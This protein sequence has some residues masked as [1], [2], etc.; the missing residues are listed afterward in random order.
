MIQF[1]MNTLLK[2]KNPAFEIADAIYWVAEKNGE[3]VGRIAAIALDMELKEKKLIRFGWIDF[4]DDL[5]VSKALINQAEEWGKQKGAEAIHGPMGFTDLDYEGALIS[6]FDQIA[7]QAAIY[8]YP[9]YAKH[10]ENLNLEKAVDWIEFRGIPPKKLPERY[11]RLA[12]II[13]KRFGIK[14]LHLKKAKDV[15]KYATEMF[16]VLNDSYSQLYGYYPLTS[17]QINYY[18]EQYLGMVRKEYICLI[19]DREDKII[20][21]GISFPSLSKAFQKAKGSLFPFGFIHILKDFWFNK[22][23]DLLLIGVTPEYQKKGAASLMFSEFFKNYI[24]NGVEYYS[25]GP[26]LEDNSPIQ[27]MWNEYDKNVPSVNIRRRCYKK[28]IS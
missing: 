8:N 11:E 4:I 20:G 17:K 12:S 9:Y 16:K 25:T 1:E 18:V 13:S 28:K 23:L 7:T 6:G 26:M 10:Y 24:K 15:R 2:E 3:I 21:I 14:A 19:V 22:H 27:N 5:E